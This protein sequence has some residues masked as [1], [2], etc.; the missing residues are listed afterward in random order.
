MTQFD[1]VISID[2]PWNESGGGK[3]K[4]GADRHYP[5]MKTK[6]MPVVIRSATWADGSPVW[7]P[8]PSGCHVWLWTTNTFLPDAL[9]LLGELGAR[10]ITNMAWVKYRTAGDLSETVL[11]D[12]ADAG[13]SEPSMLKE[14]ERDLRAGLYCPE[15]F[16]LGQYLRGNHE[17][18]LLGI[19]G[20][21]TTQCRT[22]P[23]T[24]AAARGRHSEKPEEFYE[25]ALAISGAVSATAMFERTERPGWKCWG[26]EMEGGQ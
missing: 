23:S 22:I 2:P 25:R 17:L 4:R 1:L 12:Y 24:L 9:W 19:I 5:L 3:V 8:D 26:N 15:R 20:K 16:G 6:D 11:R 7:R 18:A 21:R 10:Y 14:V 13:N